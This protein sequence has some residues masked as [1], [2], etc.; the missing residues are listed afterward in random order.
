MENYKVQIMLEDASSKYK[1]LV[2][3]KIDGLY[4]EFDAATVNTWTPDSLNQYCGHLRDR[5][6]RIL[7]ECGESLPYAEDECKRIRRKYEKEVDSLNAW[8]APCVGGNG[9]PD[10][11]LVYIRFGFG[12]VIPDE[13]YTVVDI[14]GLA[15]LDAINNLFID[16]WGFTVVGDMYIVEF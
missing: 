12:D 2:E 13:Y 8:C 9:K 10:Y 3:K 7:R 5:F 14:D 1:T 11:F 15:M 6:F 16:C 4:N